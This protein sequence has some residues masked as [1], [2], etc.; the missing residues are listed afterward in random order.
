MQPDTHIHTCAC[1]HAH[2][3]IYF[4]K[5][6]YMSS[7]GPWGNEGAEHMVKREGTVSTVRVQGSLGGGG[8]DLS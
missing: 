5:I 2:T 1:A 7:K 6:S 3:Q 8:A 4:L